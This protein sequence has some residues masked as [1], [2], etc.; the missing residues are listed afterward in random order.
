MVTIEI[1]GKPYQAEPKTML[2][3]V[4]D[5]NGIDI[6]RFCYHKKLS[7][8][9]SCRMCLVEVEKAPKP[10]PACATPVMDGMKVFTRSTKA[11]AAQ[12]AVMEFLLINHPLD[13]PICDQGGECE[14]Q[15]VA[16]GYGK[17]IS[18]YHDAKRVVF[19]KNLGPLVATEMTRCIHCTRCV[20]FSME[21]AG[22][23]ELGATGRGEHTLI[24]TYIEKN[25]ASELSGNIVDLC[26]VGALTAKPSRFTARAWELQQRDGIAPHDAIGSHLHFHI[27]RNQLIRVVPKENEAINE[28]WLSDR[29]RFSYQAI[30]AKDRLTQPMIKKEGLWQTT[31]WETA[32]AFAVDGL[33]AV[34]EK[35]QTQ[36]IGSLASPTATVEELFLLQKLMRG[37]GSPHLDH[38]L[39]QIDFSDQD[40]A[41]LF[42]ALSGSITDLEQSDV[43]LII[44]SH[45]RKE[46][47]LL[48]HRLRKAVLNGGKVVVV[49]PVDY[50]FNFPVAAKMIAAP[51]ELVNALASITHALAKNKP[52]K[53]LSKETNALLA[54]IH[55]TD[56][57]KAVAEQL[58]DAERFT[59]LLGN[60]ATSHPQ[61]GLIRAFT[62]IIAQLTGAQ[63][64]YL[65]EAANSAGAW[66][67]GVL[68][69]RLPAGEQAETIGYDAEAMLTQGLVGYI[70]LGLEPEIDSYDGATALKTL[71]QA[72]F[73]VSITAY[74]TET[75]ESYANVLLPM[76]TFAETSGTYVNCEGKWQ[77]FSGAIT[78]LAES[79]PAW[80]ILRV[81]GNLFNLK[82]F[83]YV[84][85]E[86]VRHELQ[87]LVGD[88][89]VNN[90]V[91][92]TLPES[93]PT[94][95]S[96]GLQRITEM[97]IYA[98]D[99][100]V[101]R[102]PAL[103]ATVDAQMTMG[104]HFNTHTANQ[105][106]LNG[107]SQIEMSQGDSCITLPVV[108]DERV[109]DNCV[110]L[111]GG[112]AAT[113]PL[114]AWD[115]IIE[116]KAIS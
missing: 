85:S 77:S 52:K 89:T 60:L 54:K 83:D 82:G 78:P 32:L 40:I 13:C 48:N 96:K 58:I 105:I 56:A 55:F 15:D 6:P 20:R 7:V 24:G 76:T 88:K 61:F 100:I 44:G 27:R 67:A 101:R 18:R 75:M 94:S 70:L 9:A 106:K 95:Q 35:Q 79:R 11:L 113:M 30:T 39:R 71:Q 86:E 102:A 33:K 25:V 50:E 65:P 51:S 46:Q 73:V 98:T 23:Q 19:D 47:P 107:H 17:D 112:Q 45:L 42:P 1:D 66:L 90:Q 22:V 111:Y 68:P 72:E 49:N 12:K 38:R 36:A 8:A 34:I 41:P 108:L 84:S 57:H 59:I 104:I 63:I 74:R 93:L 92:W 2:I 26:P 69:H 97:P 110:L 21:I 28:V 16:V 29:D 4:A 62:N 10:L 31:D 81:L 87:I 43:T 37:I 5:A 14:L 91:Q 115:G 116:V 109:P 99:C 114:G 64:S 103:Q 3:D 80:K 53:I